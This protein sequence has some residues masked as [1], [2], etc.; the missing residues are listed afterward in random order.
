MM[1]LEH[2]EH[3]RWIYDP[4]HPDYNS[5]R[6]EWLRQR[7]SAALASAPEWMIREA[8]LND[9]IRMKSTHIPATCINSE[10]N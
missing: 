9:A 8:Q 6:A 5:E 1:S 4:S 10:E 3:M 7:R 2:E